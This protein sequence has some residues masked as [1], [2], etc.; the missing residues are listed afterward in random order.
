[1]KNVALQVFPLLLVVAGAPSWAGE[2]QFLP[3]FLEGGSVAAKKE[4]AVPLPPHS[5][6][7]SDFISRLEAA[8]ESRDVV[9]IQALYETRGVA[10]EKMKIELSRWRKLLH[11]E[12]RTR[13]SLYGKELSTLP[14]KAREVWG[15]RAHH[16]TKH[17]VTHMALVKF[18]TGVGLMLPLVVVDDRLLIVPSD[19]VEV[20]SD[21]EPIGPAN[22]SQPVRSETNA[23]SSAAGSRR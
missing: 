8:I 21:I 23:T 16:L 7:F 22:G 9:S 18:G 3:D 17:E 19:N 12:A 20:G 1:M 5:N 10:P 14:P 13:V 15:E 11:E 2:L 6:L 4:T